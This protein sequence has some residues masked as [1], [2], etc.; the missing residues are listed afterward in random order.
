MILISRYR[1][2]L[3]FDTYQTDKSPPPATPASTISEGC[4]SS[5]YYRP[6]K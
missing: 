3:K 6:M 2:I 5:I 4:K 1:S